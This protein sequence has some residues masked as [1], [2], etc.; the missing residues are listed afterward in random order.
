[1]LSH[2]C[3]LLVLHD[4]H[5]KSWINNKPFEW[6][7]FNLIQNQMRTNVPK[8][9]YVNRNY[10]MLCWKPCFTFFFVVIAHNF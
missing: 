9:S 3:G 4:S 10:G 8:G 1:M 7:H 2:F 6:I 5:N